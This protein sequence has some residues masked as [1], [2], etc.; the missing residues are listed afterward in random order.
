MLL[1]KFKIHRPSFYQEGHFFSE[2]K[3]R[4]ETEMLDLRAT[5]STAA[6]PKFVLSGNTF[7]NTVL[8]G[9]E[10]QAFYLYLKPNELLANPIECP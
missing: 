10:T 4:Q 5:V 6:D 1:E 3:L 7:F 2:A 9:N 8:G